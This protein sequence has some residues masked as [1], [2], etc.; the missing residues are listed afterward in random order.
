MLGLLARVVLVDALELHSDTTDP[1]RDAFDLL[2]GEYP[3]AGRDAVFGV[4]R[5]WTYLP[6]VAGAEGLVDV[7]MRRAFVGAIVAPALYVGMRGRGIG[8]VVAFATA[9]VCAG[10]APALDP[11]L[12]GH[13]SYL[14]SEWSTVAVLLAAGRRCAVVAGI[15]AGLAAQNHPAALALWPGLAALAWSGGPRG[16]AR[17]FVPAVLICLPHAWLLL[18]IDGGGIDER[19]ASLRDA[20]ARLPW[21]LS[22]IARPAGVFLLGGAALALRAGRREAVAAVIALASGVLLA[23]TIDY[24]KAWMLR[25]LWPVLVLAGAAGFQGA[26]VARW[27]PVLVGLGL[28]VFG[29]GVAESLQRV[30]ST[31][32]GPWNLATV[33]AVAEASRPWS[34]IAA[35]GPPTDPPAELVPV[36]LD[37]L[38]RG[39]DLA[40]TRAEM[41]SGGVGV[42]FHGSTRGPLS[43][44]GGSVAG[45]DTVGAARRSL[46]AACVDPEVEFWAIEDSLRLVNPDWPGGPPIAWP[47]CAQPA[48]LRLPAVE[49]GEATIDP[50]GLDRRPVTHGEFYGC[51][52]GGCETIRASGVVDRP[53]LVSF[54]EATR[55]CNGGSR[56]GLPVVAQLTVARRWNGQDLS[57]QTGEAQGAT[58]S[59]DRPA[60]V[61]DF[62][63]ESLDDDRPEWVRGDGSPTVHTGS[64]AP[65]QARFRCAHR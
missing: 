12:T 21:L 22:E 16:L 24:F 28:T 5:T 20:G 58:A 26:V 62:A 11:M 25:P 4:G 19:V 56:H 9:L 7:W 53:A 2:R 27:R 44:P 38:L 52:A 33:S 14:A 18:T 34:Q 43:V 51:E 36:V 42:W 47:D 50:F 45:F 8:A 65:K 1:I 64:A 41:M 57:G 60:N 59:I 55:Y 48:V 15:A 29:L 49:L 13:S 63:L 6:L 46:R 40:G 3:W 32:P 61:S 35:V 30:G 54:D 17:L 39:Q 37:L 10:S 23:L 31:A